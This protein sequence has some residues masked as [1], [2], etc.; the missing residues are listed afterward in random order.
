[1]SK[2]NQQ[3]STLTCMTDTVK[4]SDKDGKTAV[5]KIFQQAIMN[6]LRTNKRECLFKELENSKEIEDISNNQMQILPKKYD[7]LQNKQTKPPTMVGFTAEWR[8]LKKE[9]VNL[10]Y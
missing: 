1:M 6:K 10:K 9:S 4:L 3:V 2:V 8:W 7:Y 5:I